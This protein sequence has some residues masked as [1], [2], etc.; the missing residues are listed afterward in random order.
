[1]NYEYGF[2]N[3]SQLSFLD[4][5]TC[6]VGVD[7]EIVEADFLSVE[8]DGGLSVLLVNSDKLVAEKKDH[9]R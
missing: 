7:V 8:G 1:M 5:E 6:R 9:T 2:L 3:R 4:L